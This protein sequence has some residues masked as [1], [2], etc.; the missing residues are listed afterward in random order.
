M[1]NHRLPNSRQRELAKKL[2][3]KS[4]KERRR[5]KLMKQMKREDDP[6]WAVLNEA[7][8]IAKKEG[9]DLVKTACVKKKEAFEEA[10]DCPICTLRLPSLST[11]RRCMTCCGKEVCCGCACAPVYDDQGNLLDIEKQNE[12]PFCRAEAPKSKEEAMKRMKNRVEAGDANAIYSLGC[13]HHDGSHGCVQDCIKALELYHRAAE[14]GYSDAYT[15]I[16]YAY[17]HGKGVEVDKKKAVYYYELAAMKGDEVARNNLGTME[18]N[19]GNMD[20]ALQHYMMA[21]RDG[22]HMALKRIK[23]MYTNGHATKDDTTKALQLHQ[24]YLD[25]IKSDQRDKAAAFSDVYRY[26]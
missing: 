9:E 16:G 2:A 25:E 20:R 3:K 10:K 8:A 13:Y 26:Y 7:I 6:D 19:A 18:K 11:G 21:V 15:N 22:Y 5:K 1:P 23:D 4:D 17:D 12:C 24:A 14:L